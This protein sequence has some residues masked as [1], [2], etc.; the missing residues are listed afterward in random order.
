MT[1][2]TEPSSVVAA[3]MPYRQGTYSILTGPGDREGLRPK[4]SSQNGKKK[5]GMEAPRRVPVKGA[6]E[7]GR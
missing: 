1:Y 2:F 4:K 7:A 3:E 5:K 6:K